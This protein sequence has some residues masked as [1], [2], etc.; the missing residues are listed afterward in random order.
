MV[1]MEFMAFDKIILEARLLRF[2]ALILNAT[3]SRIHVR[4]AFF[5]KTSSVVWFLATCFV[6]APAV[7]PAVRI[8]G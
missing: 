5:S 4:D 8:Y 1:V 6:L 3:D 2:P 7:K